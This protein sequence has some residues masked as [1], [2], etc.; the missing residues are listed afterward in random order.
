MSLFLFVFNLEKTVPFALRLM[1]KKNLALIEGE[2]FVSW[3]ETP[4][5]IEDWPL[6]SNIKR[7]FKFADMVSTWSHDAGLVSYSNSLEDWAD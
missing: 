1:L 3:L 4:H 7:N 2:I 5:S 6:K